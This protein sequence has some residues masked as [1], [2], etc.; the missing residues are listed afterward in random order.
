MTWPYST[1]FL[2]LCHLGLPIWAVEAAPVISAEALAKLKQADPATR[3]Q[4]I[5]LL[6]SSLQALKQADTALAKSE[7]QAMQIPQRSGDGRLANQ[8]SSLINTTAQKRWTLQ[9]QIK[10]LESALLGLQKVSTASNP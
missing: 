8:T 10:Q 9:Q 1:L 5:A 4:A 3:A 2:L 6:T 7:A